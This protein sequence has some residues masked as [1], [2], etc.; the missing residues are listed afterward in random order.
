V[1]VGGFGFIFDDDE[2]LGITVCIVDFFCHSCSKSF[3][4]VLLDTPKTS[5]VS[6]LALDAEF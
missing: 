5:F 3:A 6:S 2:P 4:F 1:R